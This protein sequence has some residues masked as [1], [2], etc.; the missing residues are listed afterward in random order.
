MV[1]VFSLG[2]PIMLSAVAVFLASWVMHAMLSYH[3]DDHRKMPAEDEVLEALHRFKLPPGDY[4]LPKP[5]S[6]KDMASPEYK[7]RLAKGPVLMATVFKGGAFNMGPALLQWFIYCL[8]VGLF[9]GYVAGLAHGPGA[10]YM[11]V[12]RVVGTVAFCGYALALWQD[13]CHALP[14]RLAAPIS[15]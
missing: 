3:H 7:A 11:A 13:T 4:M 1:S 5:A 9:A 10:R 15:S 14:L 8:V 6:M 2:L 12:F